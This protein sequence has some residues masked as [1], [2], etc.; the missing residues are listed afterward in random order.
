MW[1]N[2]TRHI[3]AS[4][5]A[6][7]KAGEDRGR[8]MLAGIHKS[9][10]LHTHTHIHTHAHTHTHIYVI[11]GVLFL[12]IKIFLFK[13]IHSLST[14]LTIG[15]LCP[16]L[17]HHFFTSFSH[18][19]YFFSTC[20]RYFIRVTIIRRLSDIV[21]EQDIAVHTLSSFPEMNNRCVS[22]KSYFSLPLSFL[23]HI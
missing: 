14:P 17:N 8:R 2:S 20:T 3:L 13:F 5:C 7:G 6:F 9:I 16:F 21:R 4:T 22:M 10:H 11:F 19:A 12:P 15:P 23:G 18:I 1:R